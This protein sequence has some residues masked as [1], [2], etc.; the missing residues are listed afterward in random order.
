MDY[1]RWPI[2][3]NAIHD[4]FALVDTGL[5]GIDVLYENRPVGRSNASGLLLIPNLTAQSSN[6]IA[7]DARDVPLDAEVAAVREVAV[8]LDRSGVL[9]KFAV[10]RADNAIVVLQTAAG[11]PVPL[12]AEALLNGK[13]TFQVG[14]DGQ[15]YLK[16]LAA[17]NTLQ[18]EWGDGRCSVE[19]EYQAVAG[20][21]QQIGPL[22]C[23]ER[24]P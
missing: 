16:Q 7:I 3:T 18:V 17:R 6:Q 23:V 20:A 8:P 19:F 1:R 10:A 24:G 14:Y 9:V 15:A 4:S 2:L 22:R 5:P 13:D 21:Q 11:K 12:G